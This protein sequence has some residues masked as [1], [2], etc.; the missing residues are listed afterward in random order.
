MRKRKLNWFKKSCR[1]ALLFLPYLFYLFTKFVTTTNDGVQ[2]LSS[3]LLDKLKLSD[4][5]KLKYDEKCEI[6]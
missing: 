2:M 6:L 1:F 3:K 5:E 4:Y